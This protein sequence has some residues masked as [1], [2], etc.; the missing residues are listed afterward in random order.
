M[1]IHQKP[2]HESNETV[3]IKRN[4]QYV[5]ATVLKVPINEENDHY[6][7][8]VKDSG[9]IKEMNGNDISDHDPNTKPTENNEIP[10]QMYKWS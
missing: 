8:Q 9:E 10:N 7:I 4:K 2:Q 6:I 5:P 1:P 3:Y